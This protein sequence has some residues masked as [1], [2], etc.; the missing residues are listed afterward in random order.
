MKWSI[1]LKYKLVIP[2]IFLLFLF[3]N[4]FQK[5]ITGNPIVYN[6]FVKSMAKTG[7]AY[8]KYDEGIAHNNFHSP[9]SLNIYSFFYSVTNNSIIGFRVVN[10]LVFVLFFMIV[11]YYSDSK[12]KYILFLSFLIY[13]TLPIFSESLQILEP[14]SNLAYIPVFL[15]YILLRQTKRNLKYFLYLFL[16]VLFSLLIKELTG[17]ILSISLILTAFLK[18]SYVKQT[19]LVV[20]LSWVA[21][22][23]FYNTYCHYYNLPIKNIITS[24][25]YH[26]ETN[27]SIRSI[28]LNFIY[29]AKGIFKWISPFYVILFF[30]I[31]IKLVKNRRHLD[32]SILFVILSMMFSF[33]ITSKKGL[34]VPR[35]MIEFL[36]LIGVLFWEYFNLD[37]N[38]KYFKS[39]SR[40]PL[41]FQVIIFSLF[42]IYFITFSYF[43]FFSY[44]IFIVISVLASIALI[45]I[46]ELF[47]IKKYLIFI[48][49]LNIFLNSFLSLASSYKNSQSYIQGEGLLETDNAISFIRSKISKDDILIGDHVDF[50]FYFDNKFVHSQSLSEDFPIFYK[51]NNFKRDNIILRV[52]KSGNY[53]IVL[54]NNVKYNFTNF[55][56]SNIIWKKIG[57][58]NIGI[59]KNKINNYQ[60]NH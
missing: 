16:F 10:L 14:A 58:Y 26:S 48:L 19:L 37:L 52:I 17:I 1:L 22:F 53:I 6:I 36:P 32:N 50:S 20:F 33:L 43:F 25:F 35:Y 55:S 59:D 23:L 13:S 42:V 41:R 57:S 60:S 18:N 11:Y 39:I 28:F 49:F 54:R 5:P 9:F 21:F 31:V 12:L 7:E 34:F 45:L 27:N 51:N 38:S 4:Y 44:N 29:A 3:F 30:F 8:I 15:I 46:V 40:I 56:S 2:F 47:N 24:F